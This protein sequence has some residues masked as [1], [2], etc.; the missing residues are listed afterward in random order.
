MKLTPDGTKMVIS[1]TN[2]Y[3]MIIHDLCLETLAKDL[4]NFKVSI[5]DFPRKNRFT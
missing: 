5:L 3:I 4:A 1:T 2:A